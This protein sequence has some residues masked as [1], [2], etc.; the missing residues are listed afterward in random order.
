MGEPTG[1]QPVVVQFGIGGVSFSASAADRK[2][3][4]DYAEDLP[5][6]SHEYASW[7]QESN[8]KRRVASDD[9]HALGVIWYEL[10]IRSRTEID[11]RT[12]A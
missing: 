3:A 1:F 4:K 7:E 8:P 12:C 6:C 9:V 5:F 10:R 11:K 2:A